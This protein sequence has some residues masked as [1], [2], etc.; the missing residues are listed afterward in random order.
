MC[1]LREGLPA[2]VLRC[3]SPP[4]HPDSSVKAEGKANR[5]GWPSPEVDLLEEGR[6]PCRNH[7]LPVNIPVSSSDS[8]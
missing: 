4:F 6:I 3:I 8:G 7:S 5:A 2:A 1:D